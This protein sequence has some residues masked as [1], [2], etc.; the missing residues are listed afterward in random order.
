LQ[1]GEP[2]VVVFFGEN[3]VQGVVEGIDKTT[4]LIAFGRGA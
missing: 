4:A 1:K 2:V 3:P